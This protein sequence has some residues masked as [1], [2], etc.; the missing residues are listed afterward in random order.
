MKIKNIIASALALGLTLGAMPSLAEDV[1]VTEI[2]GKQYV[3][4]QNAWDVDFEGEHVGSHRWGAPYVEVKDTATSATLSNSLGNVLTMHAGSAN[5]VI[6]TE[7]T[8]DEHGSAIKMVAN[9]DAQVQFNECA[10]TATGDVIVYEWDY[11]LTTLPEKTSATIVVMQPVMQPDSWLGSL[12]VTPSEAMPQFSVGNAVFPINIGQWYTV[13]CYVNYIDRTYSYYIDGELLYKASLPGA[14]QNKGKKIVCRLS[15]AKGARCWVD[16]FKHYSLNAIPEITGIKTEGS[17]IDIETSKAIPIAEF[18]KDDVISN[19]T[20]KYK[21]KAF[22][23][24]N[25]ETTSNDKVIRFTSSEPF[26]T[27]VSLDIEVTYMGIS[28]GGKFETSPAILDVKNVTVTK[29]GSTFSAKATGHNETGEEHMAV[30]I[31]VLYDGEGRVCAMNYG[32]PQPV[33][34]DIDMFASAS[35][36]KAVSAKV[37]F[38]NDWSDMKPFK[39]MYYS[40]EE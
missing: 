5:N 15:G 28:I 21:D 25:V 38:M 11:K 20:V 36:D 8:G 37:F 16:N 30:M 27:A 31:M 19:I 24:V 3:V 13:T 17:F 18:S 34:T 33:F 14:A 32:A 22:D 29:D 9:D 1:G 6:A 40:S 26:P 12:T 35:S 4:A 2:D 39:N 7:E 10:A 23:L